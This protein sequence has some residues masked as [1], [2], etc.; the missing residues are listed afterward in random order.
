MTLSEVE[1]GSGV[2]LFFFLTKEIL[3]ELTVEP[4]VTAVDTQSPTHL[5]QEETLSRERQL[6]SETVRGV[7]WELCRPFRGE[8]RIKMCECVRV[9]MSV[10]VYVSVCAH[11]ET[12]RWK[13]KKI[14]KDNTLPVVLVSGASSL[15]HTLTCILCGSPWVLEIGSPFWAEELKV[16]GVGGVTMTTTV[17][18]NWV[19]DC[20]GT[21][22]HGDY[23][24][25]RARILRSIRN[26]TGACWRNE[27]LWENNFHSA[28]FIF[29]FLFL[30]ERG[31]ICLCEWMHP[32][33]YCMPR[34]SY[35]ICQ[36]YQGGLNFNMV[37]YTDSVALVVFFLFFCLF[38]FS[39]LFLRW[40][41][42]FFIV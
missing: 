28:V 12:Q 41:Y 37:E 17:S 3:Q 2:F 9:C 6:D 27:E 31:G 15:C 42:L 25:F 30:W 24:Y 39:W 23:G 11:T 16:G 14:Q 4:V 26:I 8:C 40:K 35:Q 38:F 32:T 33:E 29:I 7:P 13:K 22:C 18:L 5:P 20:Y 19:H 1:A 36:M 21:C 10:G 34:W